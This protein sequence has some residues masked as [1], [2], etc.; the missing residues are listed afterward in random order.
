MISLGALLA[1][2]TVA[3]SFGADSTARIITLTEAVELAERNAPAVVA[4]SGQQR[5]SAA[6]VRSAYGAFI[7]TLSLSSGATKQYPGQGGTRVE[8]GQVITLPDQ[9]WSH[10]IGLAAGVE[11]FDGGQRFFDLRQAHARETAADANAESQRY[12]AGLAAKQQYFNVLAARES[13]EAAHAQLAQAVVQLS[14]SVARLRARTATRSDSL[15]SQIQV[16][17]AQLALIDARNSL[18][19]ANASL[20]R[21]VG[22]PYLVTA[23]EDDSLE[24]TQLSLDDPGLRALAE[25]APSVQEARAEL[26]AAVASRHGAWTNYLPSLSASYSRGGNGAGGGFFP[27]SNEFSYSGAVRFSLSLPVFNQF[28]REEQVTQ[29]RVAE[30][31]AEAAL[32]DA[33]LAAHESLTQGLG[34]FRSAAERVAAQTATVEAAEEDLRVQQQRYAVGGSTQLDVLTSQAQLDQA[35]R[36]LIRARYDQRVAKAQLEALLGEEL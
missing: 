21:A 19:S 14:A 33:R 11:L 22:T 20:T 29:A 36:D 23:A 24:S 28:Q 13:E 10:S 27:E 30:D 4:A 25:N 7:P 34:A 12:A 35:R 15:R 1:S 5:M 2:A 32:R 26:T 17:N 9:P 18:E 8:N 6:G 16:S 3:G 31:N